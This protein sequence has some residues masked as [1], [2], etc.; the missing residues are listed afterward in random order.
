MRRRAEAAAGLA[1]EKK[2]KEQIK[3]LQKTLTTVKSR[4]NQYKHELRKAEKTFKEL[5][6][7]LAKT[8]EE[9]KQAKGGGVPTLVILN[10]KVEAKARAKWAVPAGKKTLSEDA[11]LNYEKQIATLVDENTQLRTSF[12][13][14]H[15][16]LQELISQAVPARAGKT[17][18]E[19]LAQ[20]LDDFSPAQIQM[21]M[22]WTGKRMTAGLQASLDLLRAHME[23][24]CEAV[25]TD[26][27]HQ[28]NPKT[29][30]K[31]QSAA[32]LLAKF[33]EQNVLLAAQDRLLQSAV[34]APNAANNYATPSP[35]SATIS[36]PPTTSTSP[37]RPSTTMS[38]TTPFSN[39]SPNTAVGQR[40]GVSPPLSAPV[41]SSNTFGSRLPDR[42]RS[43]RE[44][45]GV[46]S[47]MGPSL[48][49]ERPEA[50][51]GG[52]SSPPNSKNERTMARGLGGKDTLLSP[53]ARVFCCC[54]V[55]FCVLVSA[56]TAMDCFLISIYQYQI[57]A[58]AA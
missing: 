32:V 23:P 31:E 21:P 2:L 37:L 18:P 25:G 24:A 53:Y 30:P 42:E 27:D 9:K 39:S 33:D 28:T 51:I 3:E 11:V 46:T 14:L 4:D 20:A 1:A 35:L 48:G 5:Q 8:L 16:Q 34:L 45:L 13:T 36:T 29:L 49:A 56:G 12:E 26:P 41:L 50:K 57:R 19:E 17:V 7:R 6:D 43:E 22:Q 40:A 44:G 10:E 47:T 58:P 55:V 38:M 15:A 52:P 54:F